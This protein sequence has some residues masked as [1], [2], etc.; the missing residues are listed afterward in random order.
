MGTAAAARALGRPIAGKTGSTS[1]YFDGWFVGFTPQVATGVWVGFDEE[2]S[3]GAGEVGGRNALPI[4]IDYMKAVLEGTPERMME[5]PEGLVDRL[6]NKQTGRSARPD[7]AN[8]MFELFMEENDPTQAA[9]APV[10]AP[11]NAPETEDVEP[12]IEIIF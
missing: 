8:T 5:R 1:G 2:R 10:P 3:L 6:V 4:W 7:Q 9:A 11:R 12:T